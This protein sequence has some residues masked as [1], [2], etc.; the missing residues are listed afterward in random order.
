MIWIYRTYPAPIKLTLRGSPQT[1]RDCADYDKA[2][3]E[4]KSGL[5]LFSYKSYYSEK[6]VKNALREMHHDKCCYCET[7]LSTPAYLHV[8]HFRPKAAV[9]QS[10]TD[11]DERPGYYW[12]AYCWENLLLACFECNSTYKGTVFP[13]ENTAQRAHSHN[14]DLTKERELFVNPTVEDP[15][16]HIRFEDD[17]P[18]AQ[19]PRGRHTIEG[20]GLR[21]SNL[22]DARREW[23]DIIERHIDIVKC[24]PLPDIVE[25][26]DEARR[27]IEK[28]MQSDA[29]FSSMVMARV[30]LRG[31]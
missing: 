31:L 2:P 4:F 26:Q 17:L 21:R 27:F 7:K 19:T 16:K 3:D 13:L 10:S 18:V 12:M 24:P 9:R 11:K 15:R 30:V 28:A 5:R 25:L 8:E 14:D 20:L 22:S 6:T 1:Q 29:Q 23:F